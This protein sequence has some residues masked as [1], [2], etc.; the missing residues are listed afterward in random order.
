MCG[1]EWVEVVVAPM[2]TLCFYTWIYF[3]NRLRTLLKEWRELVHNLIGYIGTID[4]QQSSTTDLHS[5]HR[6]GSKVEG[7][8]A[9]QS[10][11]S[12]EEIEEREEREEEGDGEEQDGEG[13][14]EEEERVKVVIVY[15]ASP[16]V[17]NVE[18]EKWRSSL[19]YAIDSQDTETTQKV[20][21][22]E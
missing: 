7:Q 21:E 19:S 9:D 20:R 12:K 15:E 11:A 4:G 1:R 17:L 16:E 14:G 3:L 6:T 13:G 8:I 5:P 10:D 18:V 2:Y 22:N